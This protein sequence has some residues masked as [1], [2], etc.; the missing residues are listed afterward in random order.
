MSRVGDS[1]VRE[2][3]VGGRRGRPGG[4]GR[5]PVPVSGTKESDTRGRGRDGEESSVVVQ[6]RDH[7]CRHFP[8]GDD[9]TL[10]ES[11]SQT[12]AD[13]RRKG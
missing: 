10:E 4:G 13:R 11:S 9:R 6:G 12:H 7:R 2:R 3:I 1:E 8:E 5:G